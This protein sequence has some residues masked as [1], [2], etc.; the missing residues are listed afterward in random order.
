MAE[1]FLLSDPILAYAKSAPS[2]LVQ[3][4]EKILGDANKLAG[5]LD[6]KFHYRQMSREVFEAKAKNSKNIGELNHF[7]WRDTASTIKAYSLSAVYR[8][9]D[10][11]QQTC[12]LLNAGGVLGPAILAR[13]QIELATV[14]ILTAAKLRTFVTRASPHWREKRTVSFELEELLGKALHGSRT[15]PEDSPYRQTNVLT[16]IKQL[17]K[18]RG[19]EDVFEY[20]ERLCE[21]AHPNALGNARFWAD[22]G[23]SQS[24]GSVLWKGGPRVENTATGQIKDDTLWALA[25]CASSAIAAFR[26]AD[27]QIQ[28]ISRAFP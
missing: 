10:L 6:R 1:S 22:G 20:Y 24:D 27:E 2:A 21:V 9:L 17:S 14:F 18:S 12:L 7:Y 28:R 19:F 4:L 15:V 8:L 5:I 23:A 11:V 13:S 26:V 16:H 25:W 3:N